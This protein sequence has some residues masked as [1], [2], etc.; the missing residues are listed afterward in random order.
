MTVS[1]AGLKANL[2]VYGMV[3]CNLIYFSDQP[4]Y[5]LVVGGGR[6]DNRGSI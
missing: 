2:P 4:R 1:S 3:L 5:T 6:S